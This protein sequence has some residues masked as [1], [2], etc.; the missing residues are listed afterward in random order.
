MAT[1]TMMESAF[2]SLSC[3]RI[4]SA[5]FISCHIPPSYRLKPFLRVSALSFPTQRGFLRLGAWR[6]PGSKPLLA[7][8]T[9]QRTTEPI[10][11]RC[12]CTT[13]SQRSEALNSMTYDRWHKLVLC[14]LLRLP[15][16]ILQ[17]ASTVMFLL[18]VGMTTTTLCMSLF[19]DS[20]TWRSRWRILHIEKNI[21]NGRKK[22]A[23]LVHFFPPRSSH[24]RL[25][26]RNQNIQLHLPKD[27]QPQPP[28][29]LRVPVLG[30]ENPMNLRS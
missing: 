4:D 1:S 5:F 30:L 6:R 23:S 10:R 17:H 19:A 21:A 13:L 18:V 8:P 16:M 26:P 2:I 20:F 22:E 25:H 24:H 28:N 12:V 14:T 29:S 15:E 11:K 9:S 7:G 27:Q 3:F